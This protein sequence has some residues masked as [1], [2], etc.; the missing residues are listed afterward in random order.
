VTKQTHQA[1]TQKVRLGN[2]DL[3]Y[4]IP[5][6][7]CK[8]RSETLF[9]KEPSTIAWLTRIPQGEVLIDVGANVGM[10]SIYAAATRQARV[11]AVEPESQNFS[12]L[13]RNIY[14]NGLNDKISPFC[15]SLSDSTGLTSL[16]L[17]SFVPDGGS[18]CHSSHQEVGFDLQPRSSPFAQGV[19]S[20]R[21]DDAIASGSFPVPHAIKIDVDGFEHLV[22]NGSIETLSNP[23]VK[24]LSI[25]VNY[26]LAEHKNMLRE[27]EAL[28]FYYC[29]EQVEVSMRTEGAFKGC[30][31][32][33]LDRIEST[34]I[35]IAN[36]FNYEKR[37]FHEGNASE[38]AFADVID[39]IQHS[40]VE[41]KP[42]PAIYLRDL[43]PVK[44]YEEMQ[45]FFPLLDQMQS[46]G[47]T[48][49]VSS[50]AYPER[51]VTLFTEEHF[52]RL[53]Q[54]Q[55]DFW[56]NF[57]QALTSEEFVHACINKFMPWCSNRLAGLRDRHNAVR[58]RNDALLVNDRTNYAIGPHTDLPHRL[59]SLL[60]YLPKDESL[61]YLG[62]S[63]YKH[64]DP[65]FRCPGGPH[66]NFED[67]ARLGSAPFLP[68]SLLMFVRTGTS[69]H[70]VE[71][72][73]E[74]GIER[75]LLISNIRLLDHDKS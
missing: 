45:R 67:F 4:W 14:I 34:S 70:G 56:G 21:L 69:F 40:F 3:L 37:A 2:T 33:I 28:G 71:P 13:C 26:N 60:F 73:K 75:R 9:T 65:N 27:L 20:F 43:F 1:F 5:N 42:F 50:G 18:S 15:I 10:Y 24:T 52:Q 23:R 35:A 16:Y 58:V 53:D 74:Q 63:F 22:I 25:E 59:I 47:E 51:L 30:A 54:T 46:L 39:K 7:I 44:Y 68:N 17:S 61:R 41:T 19:A 8:W 49:R 29:E 36:S 32:V 62:T 64:N 12:T 72:I 55:H 6:Q 57:A 48:G 11:I 31:E 38:S 66:Y